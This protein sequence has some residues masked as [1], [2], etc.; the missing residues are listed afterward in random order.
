MKNHRHIVRLAL[1]LILA[2]SAPVAADP[3]NVEWGEI[4]REELFAPH[5]AEA[6]HAGAVVLLDYAVARVD[7]K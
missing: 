1:A 4:P 7:S 3:S 2:S 6:P 5:F